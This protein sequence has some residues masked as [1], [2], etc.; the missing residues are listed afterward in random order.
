M[1]KNIKAREILNSKGNF[2]VEVELETGQGIFRASCPSG[3]SKG[4]NEAVE[5]KASE[6]V[7]NV[8]EIIGPKLKRKNPLKQ[9]EID[10]MMLEL[11]NTENKSKLGANAI[12]PVSLAICRAGAAAKKL[13]LYQYINEL[14][15]GL[16]FAG[17]PRPCFNIING[18]A[19]SG[20]ELE[21]QEFMIVPNR[22]FF[23]ENL[24]IG[25]QVYQ[26]LKKS[27]IKIFGKRAINVGDEG[28]F[29]PPISLEREAL[30][31]LQNTIREYQN[32]EIGLD[33]AASQFYKNDH[34]QI[35]GTVFSKN[36]LMNFYQNLIEAYPLIFLEDPFGESDWESFQEI[37][38]K[39][40]KKII[41][42]GDDLLVTNIERVKEAKK[43]GTCNGAIIKPNQI[44]TITG[45]LEV[46]RLARS[47]GWKIM[48]SHRSGETGDD[49]I[50]D[51][52]VGISADF[53]KSGAPA[54]GE[55]V[56]KYNRLLK[57]ENELK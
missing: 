1:I 36:G 25:S 53:I 8:N 7:K 41:I 47:F 2:T 54:R 40:G 13:P 19:H 57:I 30:D 16:T 5:I 21:I 3:A 49:F 26:E 11:D 37:T 43:K 52:A 6:A 33:C 34:Y 4:I 51:L 39:F 20:S 17:F 50:A 18:G 12:L 46:V 38:G 23:S 56:A 14:S 55:R 29:V 9:K 44:G 10:E 35:D 22:E 45:T 27:L 15:G 42:F 48:V 31:L 32:T 28:G 24:K